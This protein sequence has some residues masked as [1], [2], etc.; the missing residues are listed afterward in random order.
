MAM[1]NG[2]DRGFPIAAASLLANIRFPLAARR[3]AEAEWRR[4]DGR[5]LRARRHRRSSDGRLAG[6]RIR[7]DAGAPPTAIDLRLEGGI[8]LP[9]SS[10]C[11]THLDKGHIWPR[12]PNPDGTFMGAL[13]RGPARTARR[14]GR[15]RTSPAH[16]F[17]AALRLRPWHQGDPHPSRFDRR[18]RTAISWPVFAEMRER[19]HGRIDAAGVCLFGIEQAR[20]ERW[21][22]RLADIVAA[23]RRRARLPS[24]TWCPI[25]THC[26]TAS[27]APPSSSGST[28]ISTPTRP[29]AARA[30][31]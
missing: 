27:S 23:A 2:I 18:R 14:T 17:R 22:N 9:V 29:T 1:A 12:K 5:G 11:H 28:S 4:A 13:E 26:S 24:P 3:A 31:R 21:F 25:S 6:F 15:P 16:G 10:T 7:P 20:D 8:V 19:W 30:S